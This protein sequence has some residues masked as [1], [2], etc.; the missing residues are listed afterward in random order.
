MGTRGGTCSRDGQ[1]GQTQQA[2]RAAKQ[3][4]VR[5][6]TGGHVQP[7]PRGTPL[8]GTHRKVLTSQW[9]C[10]AGGGGRARA[11]HC[12]RALGFEAPWAGGPGAGGR[13]LGVIQVC[14]A[15]S[16]AEAGRAALVLEGQRFTVKG[17]GP[18][19]GPWGCGGSGLEP[20]GSTV[21][22]PGQDKDRC[23]SPSSPQDWDKQG[24]RAAGGGPAP[25]LAE[26]CSQA[27]SR[28][29]SSETDTD[30]TRGSG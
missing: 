5:L 16:K 24:P 28:T 7:P 20:S 4:G 18:A 10:E 26:H 1:K 23:G 22:D 3:A 21:V 25:T 9:G 6:G 15:G 11:L 2:K 19:A 14:L 29:G 30:S 12:P 17:A 13:G 27:P 8:D